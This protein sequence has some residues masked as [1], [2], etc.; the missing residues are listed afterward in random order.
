MRLSAGYGTPA[1]GTTDRG[2][3]KGGR[4]G[5]NE[6]KVRARERPCCRRRRKLLAKMDSYRK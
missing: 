2:I 6:N 4:R 3:D 5:Y 1:K